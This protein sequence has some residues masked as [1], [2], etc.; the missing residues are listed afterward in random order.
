MARRGALW[1]L[2]LA[3]LALPA[4]AG[5]APVGAVPVTAALGHPHVGDPAP[6][7]ELPDASGQLVKL[8]SLRGS[9]VVVALVASWCPY[10][11]AEQAHLDELGKAYGPR[12]VKV[13][14]VVVDD[15]E[16]GYKKYCARLPMAIPVLRDVDDKAAL[17]YAPEHA[18]PS[19]KDR[20]KVVVTA[21]LVIDA[22]GVIRYY[23]LID[24]AHFDAELTEVRAAVDRLLAPAS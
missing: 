3:L 12:G 20:R 10:S 21:N 22:A 16:K 5:K 24:T 11:K 18:L 17:A 13:L 2:V 4:A 23:G 15:S 19:F 6:D 1:F 14:A 8:S 9:V 7:F